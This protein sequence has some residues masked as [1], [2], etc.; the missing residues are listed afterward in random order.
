MAVPRSL[1]RWL[2]LVALGLSA[3]AAAAPGLDAVLQR[4]LGPLGPRLEAE[5]WQP[6]TDIAGSAALGDL[7]RPADGQ[8]QVRGDDCFAA[9]R[10]RTT[11][12]RDTVLS[13]ALQIEG[14]LPLV[15]LGARASASGSARVALQAPEVHEL[16]I[17]EL[18][19]TAA[20]AALVEG[21]AEDGVDLGQVTVI[22]S[23]L[24][25]DL[26]LEGCAELGLG[27]G[28]GGLGAETAVS[29]CASLG[30]TSTVV[31]LRELPLT[32]VWTRAGLPLV[33]SPPPPPPRRRR[34]RA[35]PCWVD[36]A[37]TPAR[38]VGRRW[39]VGSGTSLAEADRAARAAL[40]APL[41]LALAAASPPGSTAADELTRRLQ[42]AVEL[43][44]RHRDS[45]SA[46]HHSLALLDTAA[47]ARELDT[48]LAG[49]LRSLAALDPG[50]LAARSP[51]ARLQLLTS[52]RPAVEQ[53][54]LLAAARGALP[55]QAPALPKHARAAAHRAALSAARNSVQ[56]GIPDDD[57]APVLRLAVGLAGLRTAAPGAAPLQLSLTEAQLARG[58]VTDGLVGS[59]ASGLHRCTAAAR[60]V[61]SDG[62]RP[63][64]QAQLTVSVA[65]TEPERCLIAARRALAEQALD[66]AT[67]LLSG[68]SLP[69]VEDTP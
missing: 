58:L 54:N 39:A 41:D 3:T 46:T 63:V 16:P 1:P 35:A 12:A 31:A 47:L 18:Q 55:G 38:A 53:A 52:A 8:L 60:L 17:A 49:T 40:L 22:Q 20:C 45:R 10:P 11:A 2:P 5:G 24:L 27:A 29:R 26:S 33:A 62:G 43:P 42:E 66:R 37:C 69:S 6:V 56:V 28:K 67:A 64:A 9:A 57:Y 30:A 32:E 19:P 21:W 51:W 14:G 13:R 68:T 23:V 4:S 7:R 48:E 34:R 15:G 44:A 59:P 61:L 50:A 36:R 25:A 65:S